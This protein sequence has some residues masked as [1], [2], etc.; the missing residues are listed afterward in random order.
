M[1]VKNIKVSIIGYS[2]SGKST[3]AGV[4]AQ[5]YQIPLMYLDTVQFSAGWKE[6]E[7]TEARKIVADFM[8][9]DSWVIDGNYNKFYRQERLDNASEIVFMNFNRV[10][11]VFRA[12]K[13]YF[14]YRNTTRESMTEGCSEKIDGEFLWWLI[15]KGRTLERRKSF[16]AI[17]SENKSKTV[18]IKNQ[19]QLDRYMRSKI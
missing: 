16:K 8:Q 11:C 19:K 14:N 6:R 1:T 17:V 3:L 13:R 2:G 18:V 9:N 15:F 4:L 12:V 7:I 10:A 5:Q